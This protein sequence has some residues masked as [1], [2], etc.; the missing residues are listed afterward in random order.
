MAYGPEDPRPQ[1]PTTLVI[2][3]AL[4][5]PWLLPT[6]SQV[7]TQARPQTSYD[8]HAGRDE[9]HLPVQSPL[10]MSPPHSP[11]SP[12]SP[13]EP[14]LPNMFPTSSELDEEGRAALHPAYRS[15]IYMPIYEPLRHQDH[16]VHADGPSPASPTS[17]PSPHSAYGVGSTPI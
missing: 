13:R 11:R 6:L 4:P 9:L 17:H 10:T 1:R 2:D 5:S 15:S 3:T 8:L 14:T 16:E 12:L 7:Q